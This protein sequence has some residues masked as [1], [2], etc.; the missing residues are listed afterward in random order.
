[1]KEAIRETLSVLPGV[2]LGGS[3]NKFRRGRLAVH[4]RLQSRVLM[5]VQRLQVFPRP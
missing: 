2:M 3:F 1:M 4:K 5:R